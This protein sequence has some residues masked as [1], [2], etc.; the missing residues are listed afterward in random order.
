LFRIH[1]DK[2]AA[3]LCEAALHFFTDAGLLRRAALC[4]VL[5]G[6]LH[7]RRG[8]DRAAAA[9][10]RRARSILATMEAPALNYEA[11]VL[12]ASIYEIRGRLR[13]A[14]AAYRAACSEFEAIRSGLRNDELKVSFSKDKLYAYERLIRICLRNETTG[15]SAEDAFSY[16]ELAKSRSLLDSLR[17]RARPIGVLESVSTADDR[18]IRDLRGEV[19]WFHNRIETEQLRRDGVRSEV[20]QQLQAEASRCETALLRALRDASRAPVEE[21]LLEPS[22]SLTVA[23]IRSSLAPDAAIIEY[24]ETNDRLMAAV[25]TRDDLRIVNLPGTSQVRQHLRMVQFHMSRLRSGAVS[26]D[27]LLAQACDVH[28]KKLYNVLIA[29]IRGLTCARHLVIAPHGI[30]HNVPFHALHD[31]SGPLIA[32]CRI[33]YTP[34]A[35]VYTTCH[36]KTVNTEGPAL[37]LGAPDE[38]APWILDEVRGISELLPNSMLFVGSE[39]TCE[40]LRTIGPESR[41][42]HIAAH[43]YFR[44]DN[45]LLSSLRLGDCSL[46]LCDLYNLRMPVELLALSGC[47]TGLNVILEG[48]ELV[49]LARGLLYAGVRTLLLT[50]WDVHDASTARFM[51]DFYFRL[52]QTE[53]SEAF[54]QSV[55]ALR[56]E[57]PHPYY[58]APFMIFGY[59]Y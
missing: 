56:E 4:Y 47:G 13:L 37:I 9:E 23:E 35:S 1:R 11:L 28:L 26:A 39:A 50:Q 20:I 49:G 32:S 41:S 33:S 36:R 59:A 22:L 19:N 54:Q 52:R 42:I 45:P 53:A 6:R 29:P 55:L 27:R 17:G 44:R 31:G 5:L 34:S 48:D 12:R 16:M 57:Y 15:P 51:Q 43:C 46:R 24:F 40:R 10:C 38:K 21:A 7:L 14:H 25:L 30:L 58:W 3:E 8:D 2:E 18:K